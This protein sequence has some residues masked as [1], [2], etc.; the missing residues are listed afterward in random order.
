MFCI[1]ASLTAKRLAITARCFRHI[2]QRCLFQHIRI[3]WSRPFNVWD[4]ALALNPELPVAVQSVELVAVDEDNMA[5]LTA[6]IPT[7]Q[8]GFALTNIV[9]KQIEFNAD[10]AAGLALIVPHSRT[11]HMEG[12]HYDA[13]EIRL[14]LQLASDLDRLHVGIDDICSFTGITPD[15][16]ED[17][18]IS[19]V[20]LIPSAGSPIKSFSYHVES[21]FHFLLSSL[22]FTDAI[23]P[24][25]SALH[26]IFIC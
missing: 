16:D 21:G 13:Q 3:S 25:I 8:Q 12:C 18:E 9:L 22:A 19:T 5:P 17:E 10:I 15:D 23:S 2:A 1:L 20:C 7:L 24:R 26:S 6:L 14:L 11:V 4:E